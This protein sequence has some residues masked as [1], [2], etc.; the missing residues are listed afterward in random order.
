MRQPGSS[1]GPD[2]TAPVIAAPL[3]QKSL[4]LGT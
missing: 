2:L 3:D 1:P 4:P